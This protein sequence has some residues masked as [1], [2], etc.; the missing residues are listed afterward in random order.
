MSEQLPSLWRRIFLPAD[1]LVRNLRKTASLCIFSAVAL[2]FVEYYLDH[3]GLTFWSHIAQHLSIAA[4]VACVSI[5]GIEWNAKRRSDLEL[6][7]LRKE[8]EQHRE[9]ISNDVFAAVLG[10]MIEPAL[11]DEV[12]ELL[13]GPF[14]KTNC[15]YL[16]RFLPPY[17]GMSTEYCVLRRDA[18]FEI[19]NI[20]EAPRKFP[21]RSSYTSDE[22][23]AAAAWMGRPFHLELQVEGV[24]IPKNDFLK[25]DRGF[26]LAYDVS[27]GPGEAAKV[28]I[29]GEEPIP[30]SSA[31]SFYQQST[32]M[33]GLIVN[34]ENNHPNAIESVEVLMH[35]PGRGLR[36][37][38][39]SV[40]FDKKAN[41]YSLRR[42]FVPGQGFEVIWKA[43]LHL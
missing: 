4:L 19:K 32:P 9:D 2:Y 42:A 1:P 17:T 16:F 27:L 43:R 22:V 26:L 40:D 15:H 11:V 8:F 20:S 7:R 23:S 36:N 24:D 12:Q 6:D 13:R 21:L 25:D 18:S 38:G 14:I 37:E 35:H 5:F 39:G 34:I 10:R 30:I 33:D 29:R 31:R 41:Q 28:F 3:H